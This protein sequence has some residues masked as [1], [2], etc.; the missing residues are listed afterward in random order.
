MEKSR[1]TQPVENN[2]DLV[3]TSRI[4]NIEQETLNN[5]RI[6]ARD[7]NNGSREVFVGFFIVLATAAMCGAVYRIPYLLIIR[8]S[9]SWIILIPFI[10]VH[11]MQRRQFRKEFPELS[12]QTVINGL[13]HAPLIFVIIPC[14]LSIMLIYF[15]LDKLGIVIPPA[16]E[17]IVVMM[18]ASGFF[19]GIGW[20]FFATYKN[21]RWLIWGTLSL[22]MV[23]LLGFDVVNLNNFPLFFLPMGVI[24]LFTG[25]FVNLT[26]SKQRISK[27]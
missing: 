7:I 11:Q 21:W 27:E 16:T 18:I 1:S 5:A 8:Q 19:S 10:I 14:L 25:L 4:S 9:F 3:S 15:Q 22:V 24:I 6:S 2:G 20:F 17:K 12:K 23:L 26:Q 13:D